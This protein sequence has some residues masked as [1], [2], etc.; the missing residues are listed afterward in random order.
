[1]QTVQVEAAC[2]RLEGLADQGV[3][4]FRGIPFGRSARFRPSERAVPWAGVRQAHANGLIASQNPH[5]FEGLIGRTPGAQGEDCLN[6]NVFAPTINGTRRPV[7]VWIHGG[8]F[9]TGSGCFAVYDGTHLAQ[10][11]AVVVTINYRLG[12]FGFLRL[13]GQGNGEITA[14][15]TEG[16]GDQ[17]LALRWV[18][19]N[20]AAFGGD[21]GNVTL[22]GESAGSMSVASLLAAPAAKGL[23]HKAILQSGGAHVGRLPDHADRIAARFLK[24]ADLGTHE[25]HKLRDAPREHLLKAQ[26]AVIADA[27]QPGDPHHLGAMPFQPMIDGSLLPCMPIDAIRHA[28]AAGI[29]LIAGTT[30]EE[31]KL[32]AGPDTR[33]RA[34]DEERLA[35][36]AERQFG[37]YASSL[38][39][40]DGRGSA[41][42]RY[43][44]MQTTRVFREPTLRLLAAQSPLA[45]VYE[46]VFDW[47]SPFLDGALGACHALELGFVFGTYG[48]EPANQFFGSGPQ[49][50]AVSQAMM[51]AWVSFARDGVPVISGVEAWPQWRAQS[52][53]AMVFGADSRPAHVVEFEIDA[54]WHGLPDGLVGT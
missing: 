6:L 12:A 23:F 41:F 28:S 30:T 52:P 46:Y 48:M 20:I 40:A 54:A 5:I 34:M 3:V 26:A 19:D 35:R 16:L 27:D 44:A 24:H 4:A 7:L 25:A 8:A 10:R 31:W 18:R 11:G 53:A 21:P 38:L 50:D 45:P 36:W 13:A 39:A 15:G 49:A 43:V 2:G 37:D 42:E 17:I 47:R 9:V 29:P 32:W 33:L 51:A 14:T 1:M 22:F